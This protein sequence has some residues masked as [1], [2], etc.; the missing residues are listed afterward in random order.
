MVTVYFLFTNQSTFRLRLED[1]ST[2]DEPI[3]MKP[4]DVIVVT[5]RYPIDEFSANDS[6]TNYVLI[7]FNVQRNAS[8]FF[9]YNNDHI[10]VENIY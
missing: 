8:I 9:N 1:S 4:Y 5:N 10:F 3:V 6:T 7:Q 2:F